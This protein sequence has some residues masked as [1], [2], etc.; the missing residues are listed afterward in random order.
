MDED[1]I[2]EA[3]EKEGIVTEIKCPEAFLIAKKYGI[4]KSEIAAYCNSAGVKIRACQL[5]C[6]R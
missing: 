4:K 5:G 2:R 6:F 1:K 3:F